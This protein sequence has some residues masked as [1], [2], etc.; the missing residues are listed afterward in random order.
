MPIERLMP[1]LLVQVCGECGANHSISLRRGAQKTKAGP[2]VLEEG[3]TLDLSIDDG[4]PIRVTFRRSDVRQLDRVTPDEL[5]AMLTAADPALEAREDFGGCLIESRSEG[6]GSRLRIVGGSA[7]EAL[8]LSITPD[9]D[10]E[11]RPPRLGHAA[12]GSREPNVIVLRRCPCGSHEVVL[13]T[14]DRAPPQ[15]A[16]SFFDRHRR[17]AN[18][19]AEQLKRSGQSHPALAEHHANE[20]GVPWDIAAF[21]FGGEL[22][23]GPPPAQSLEGE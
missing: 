23:V 10:H 20:S 22:V 2:F 19:L 9:E 18:T 14:F 13:R 8:G 1:A 16:G 12:G 3:T 5:A 6:P 17:A 15:V 7:C 21:V 11:G 4:G